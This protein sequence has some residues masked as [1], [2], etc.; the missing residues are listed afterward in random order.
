M[1]LKASPLPVIKLIGKILLEPLFLETNN[2]DC[3]LKYLTRCES[4]RAMIS[5]VLYSNVFPDGPFITNVSSLSLVLTS[6]AI[7]FFACS[8][9]VFDIVLI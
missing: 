3:A 4:S 5:T 6:F 1:F 8:R 2:Q 9:S 7:P